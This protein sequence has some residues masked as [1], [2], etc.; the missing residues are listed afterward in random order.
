MD[1][2]T[3]FQLGIEALAQ[4][5]VHHALHC[6][7]RAGNAGA[8]ADACAAQRWHCWML[9]GD[10]ERAW[11]ECDAIDQRNRTIENCFWDG[12]PFDG[13]RVIVRSLHGY[14]DA[15][16]FIRYLPLLKQ[17]AARVIVETH[18]ELV[19]L[20]REQPYVDEVITWVDKSSVPAWDQQI[21]I[22]ELP[23][24]FRTHLTTIPHDVP[25]LR[26]PDHIVAWCGR[27]LERYTGLRVGIVWAASDWNIERNIPVDTLA[28]L[29]ATPGVSFFSFQ[30]GRPRENL[31]HLQ[32]LGP[33]C[34]M[35]PV[36]SGIVDTA[37]AFRHMD[38]LITVDTLAAHLGG[39]LARPVWTLLHSASDWRWMLH[40]EDSPWYPTMRLF[41]QPQPRDWTG[42]I[43]RVAAEL[44]LLA[45]PLTRTTRTAAAPSSSV[46]TEAKS[47]TSR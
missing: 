8:G 25:Y 12:Q 38:L 19:S 24:A 9:L 17:R 39:A 22:M 29:L 40:R 30:H 45:Y 37:A 46:D 21:E 6:F 26:A 43:E 36:C 18:P 16:Q 5:D 1:A 15:V 31:P 4:R 35:A 10:F 33:I 44:A 3:A 41:R 23:R 20:I 2:D 27:R 7:N 11:Q 47:I 32:R 13:K 14:G 42:L 34:D 28:P